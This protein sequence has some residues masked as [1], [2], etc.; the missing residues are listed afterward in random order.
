MKH[1]S[2]NSIQVPTRVFD[3][4]DRANGKKGNDPEWDSGLRQ[5]GLPPALWYFQSAIAPKIAS[6]RVRSKAGEPLS[7]VDLNWMAYF[8]SSISPVLENQLLKSWQ[9][10]SSHKYCHNRS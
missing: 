2:K 8:I 9:N 6:V 7:S 4:D 10:Q 3:H 5:E 1:I